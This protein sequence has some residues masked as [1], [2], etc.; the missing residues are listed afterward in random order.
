MLKET[1]C[2]GSREAREVVSYS[3][4]AMPHA[5]VYLYFLVQKLQIV[6]ACTQKSWICKTKYCS[7]QNRIQMESIRYLKTAIGEGFLYL[8]CTSHGLFNCLRHW[9]QRGGVTKLTYIFFC[10]PCQY[11]LSRVLFYVMVDHKHTKIF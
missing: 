2:A 10:I 5:D 9:Y 3:V 6:S 4:T 11:L 1:H 7:W 8:I